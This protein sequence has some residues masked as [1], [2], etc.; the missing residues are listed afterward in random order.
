MC[1][2]AGR[3]PTAMFGK[4]REQEFQIEFGRNTPVR[5]DEILS[6][7]MN[8][9]EA[10]KATGAEDKFWDQS[11]QAVEAILSEAKKKKYD[12]NAAARAR[13]DGVEVPGGP[14]AP[15][16]VADIMGGGNA[17][18]AWGKGETT[19]VVATGGQNSTLANKYMPPSMRQEKGG[20]SNYLNT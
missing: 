15:G 8:K 4:C 14:G 9:K 17:Q 20:P 13:A 18:S 2:N 7:E 6:M 11:L 16:S 10:L 3:W 1:F 5:S 12:A 19:S